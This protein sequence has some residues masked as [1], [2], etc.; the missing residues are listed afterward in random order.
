MKQPLTL[1]T[2]EPSYFVA[3]STSGRARPTA[4]TVA[5]ESAGLRLL[6]DRF[7]EALAEELCVR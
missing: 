5:N 7:I 6:D 2:G 4:L 3:A 1:S